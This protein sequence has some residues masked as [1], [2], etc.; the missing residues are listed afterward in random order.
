MSVMVLGQ[1][2][3]QPAC[4]T[5]GPGRRSPPEVR[6]MSPPYVQLAQQQAENRSGGREWPAHHGEGEIRKRPKQ[7]VKQHGGVARDHRV[8]P[9]GTTAI[10]MRSQMQLEPDVLRNVVEEGR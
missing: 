10:V 7:S 2:D 1:H 4:D 9:I 3:R 6:G 5:D 8:V